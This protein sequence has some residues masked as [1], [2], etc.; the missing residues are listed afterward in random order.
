MR[1]RF[2]IILVLFCFAYVSNGQEIDTLKSTKGEYPYILPILGKKAF[3]KGYRLQLPFG[4]GVNGVYNRQGILLSDFLLDFT[5][6]GGI[7]D[8]ERLKPLSDLIEFGPSTG[9]VY[10]SNVRLD[11]W[12]LPFLAVSGYYGQ[13]TGEQT[14]TLTSPLN[15]SSTTDI[16]GQYYG[17]NLL[18]VVPAGPV[19]VSADY[20]W[21]WTTNDRLDAP[22][23]IEISGIRVIK[24]ILNRNRPDRFFAF[25]AGAQ[26][27]KLEDT[28]SGKIDLGEALGI[29][30]NVGEELDNIWDEY[31]TTPRWDD[32]TLAQKIEAE[33]KYQIARGIV[34]QVGETIVHYNFKKQLE[35]NWNMLVGAQYQFN[36]HWQIRGEYGFLESKRQGMIGLNYRFGF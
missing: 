11:A 29:E 7:P 12:V 21:S 8:F 26:F 19:N 16:N 22:V 24:Q 17:L 36:D 34:E 18:A 28:T 32:L 1:R 9:T 13:V 3:E 6:L 10:T 31:K 5:K 4:I 27:Q 15:Y 14:I 2:S 25:W 20:S 23:R 30:G 33:A 35:F